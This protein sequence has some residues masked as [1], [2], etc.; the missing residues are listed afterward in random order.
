MVTKDFNKVV[1]QW[2]GSIS[3]VSPETLS[4]IR[5]DDQRKLDAGSCKHLTPQASEDIVLDFEVLCCIEQV[6]TEQWDT[7]TPEERLL[8][9]FPTVGKVGE[10][11]D[12][13]KRGRGLIIWRELTKRFG[14]EMVFKMPDG[15]LFSWEFW[16]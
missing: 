4:K 12:I 7:L 10:Y 3:G 8:T 14:V 13:P 2:F 5:V 6:I 16:D 1:D 9:R 15:S 11:F